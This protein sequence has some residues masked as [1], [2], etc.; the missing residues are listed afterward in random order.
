MEDEVKKGAILRASVL[1]IF[2]MPESN[3]GGLW[4]P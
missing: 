1:R 3:E 2:F 4:S